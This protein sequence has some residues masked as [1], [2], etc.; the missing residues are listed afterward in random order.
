MSRWVVVG[1][2]TGW[3]STGALVVCV[4][5]GLFW[6]CWPI[7]ASATAP[8]RDAVTAESPYV[9]AMLISL[10]A[11]VALLLWLEARRQLRPFSPIPLLVV[12]GSVLRTFFSPGLSGIEP[13]FWLVLIAGMTLGSAAGWLCGVA[14]MCVSSFVLGVVGTP[15]VGQIV[16]IGCWGIVGGWLHGVRSRF[17]WLGAVLLTFPLGVLSGLGLNLIGWS[18]ES[19]TGS[20]SFIPGLGPVESA[21]RLWSYTLETSFAYDAV[22][23][24]TN[25]LFMV[26]FGY[27]LLRALR[28][29]FW[30][31][32]PASV[33]YV[34]APPSIS[35][36]TTER[37][38]RSDLLTSIWKPNQGRPDE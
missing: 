10:S 36:A 30:A 32:E 23:T 2:T 31:A 29:P 24:S 28:S 17:A 27:P 19:V 1:R 18:G 12:L 21:T 6:L 11:V 9:L 26:L 3:R 14:L 13:I 35:P 20:G 7:L 34:L 22:R 38:K 5:C 33:D 37:R 4:G 8:N 15:L 25:A 16:V